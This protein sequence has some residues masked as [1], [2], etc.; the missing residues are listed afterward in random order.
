MEDLLRS[1]AGRD[2][3]GAACAPATPF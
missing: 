1:R 3:I 2:E